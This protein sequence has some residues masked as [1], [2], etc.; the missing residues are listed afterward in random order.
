M[1]DMYVELLEHST[2]NTLATIK[3]RGMCYLLRDVNIDE[4]ITYVTELLEGNKDIV[5][6]VDYLG[7]GK[8]LFTRFNE[9]ELN[10]KFM[11]YSIVQNNKEVML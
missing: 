3:Y 1:E 6:Y 10:A 8:L 5:I 11:Q 2:F 4:T 9:H 7:Y